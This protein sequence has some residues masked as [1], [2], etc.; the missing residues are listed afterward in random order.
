M[1]DCIGEASPYLTVPLRMIYFD[2]ATLKYM[3]MG[4]DLRELYCKFKNLQNWKRG[5]YDNDR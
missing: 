3:P 2:P 5:H 4:M 1:I